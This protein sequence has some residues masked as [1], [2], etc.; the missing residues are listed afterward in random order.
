MCV[1]PLSQYAAWG[2]PLGGQLDRPRGPAGATRGGCEGA[3]G[4]VDTEAAAAA[5][6]TSKYVRC[7]RSALEARGGV[8]GILTHRIPSKQTPTQTSV[9]ILL[10]FATCVLCVRLVCG[11]VAV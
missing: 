11:F 4:T 6:T 3:G 8:G 5:R 2:V 9:F 1:S 10:L 7:I